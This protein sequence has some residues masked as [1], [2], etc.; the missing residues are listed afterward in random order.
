M[1]VPRLTE[2]GS[3]E[4]RGGE[5]CAPFLRR[6][7]YEVHADRATELERQIGDSVDD[8]EIGLASSGYRERT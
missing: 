5:R 4:A 8:P 3:A 6:Y 1:D 2:H 7:D